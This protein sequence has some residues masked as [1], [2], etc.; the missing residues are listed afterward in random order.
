[1]SE[2]K[3]AMRRCQVRATP[4]LAPA[5]LP[6]GCCCH[7]ATAQHTPHTAHLTPHTAHHTPHTS[8]FTLHTT[9]PG[10]MAKNRLVGARLPTRRRQILCFR[11]APAPF[12]FLS[13]FETGDQHRQLPPP[14]MWSRNF[15]ARVGTS[16]Q[17]AHYPTPPYRD[18]SNFRSHTARRMVLGS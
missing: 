11:Y 14:Q 2:S 7:H 4:P 15:R 13:F 18:C 8:H 5:A 10:E 12:R 17:K 9:S 3:L 16:Q 1:M 6:E